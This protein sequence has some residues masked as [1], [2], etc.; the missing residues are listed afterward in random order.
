MSQ[1]DSKTQSSL[2][3][4]PPPPTPKY[5]TTGRWPAKQPVDERKKER[6]RVFALN[7]YF[8]IF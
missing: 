5:G 8:L 2:H 4:D 1:T 6:N 7:A 3:P